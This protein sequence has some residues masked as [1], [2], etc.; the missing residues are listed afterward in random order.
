LCRHHG[1][2]LGSP[3]ASAAVGFV[4]YFAGYYIG[5]CIGKAREKSKGKREKVTE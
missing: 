1:I 5:K 2:F 4:W 3:F